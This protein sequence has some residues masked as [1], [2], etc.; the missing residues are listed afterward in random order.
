M[1]IKLHL[2]I[3]MRQII[4]IFTFSRFF[5]PCILTLGGKAILYRSVPPLTHVLQFVYTEELIQVNAHWKI[6]QF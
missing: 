3:S 2:I 6:F 4:M 5:S 1:S